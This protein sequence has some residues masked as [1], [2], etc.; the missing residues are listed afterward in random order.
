MTVTCADA[1]HRCRPRFCVR[2]MP[3]DT[4]SKEREGCVSKIQCQ[5]LASRRNGIRYTARDSF[6]QGARPVDDKRNR[7]A[8]DNERID[9]QDPNEVRSWTR[10]LR[11][12]ELQLRQAVKAVG[13]H[14]RNVR[15]YINA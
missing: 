8:T 4:T 10:S 2:G 6:S 5:A 14:I 11:C 9:I 3:A 13:T 15:D 7:G 1:Q 12:T